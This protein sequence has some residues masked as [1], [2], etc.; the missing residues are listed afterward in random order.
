MPTVKGRA[1][2][3]GDGVPLVIGEGRPSSIS[4][5]PT[6]IT[7]GTVGYLRIIIGTKDVTFFRGMPVEITSIT[8][9]EPFGWQ[10]AHLNF[11]QI[12]PFDDLSQ[13]AFSWINTGHDVVIQ[14]VK[15]VNGTPVVQ[16][17]LFNGV[18]ASSTRVAGSG[19]NGR[20]GLKLDC[21]GIL[22]AN[23]DS[24]LAQPEIDYDSRDI[25]YV[26]AR[27]LNAV[28]QKRYKRVAEVVTGIKTRS[29]GAWEQN[30]T[31]RIGDL[32]AQATTENGTKQWTVYL[33]GGRKPVIR[34]KD[35][36]TV[37]HRTA[38]GTPG[39][40]I[41]IN[42][43]ASQAVTAIYGRGVDSNSRGWGNLKIPGYNAMENV[44]FFS[45]TASDTKEIG[46]TGYVV[47]QIQW[48]LKNIWNYP[49]AQDGIF[50]PTTYNFVKQLQR[51]TGCK[52]TGKVD[53]QTWLQLFQIGSRHVDFRRAY[54]AP[55]ATTEE[56]QPYTYDSSGKVTGH[57]P[58]YDGAT[59]PRERF[60][61]YPDGTSKSEAIG[62][63]NAELARDRD[64]GNTGT[65]T[66]TGVDPETTSKYTIR[67]G[68]NIA[69]KNI[70]GET[71][72]FHIIEV[73]H[74][75]SEHTTT[76]TVDTKCRDLLTLDVI[77]QRNRDAL[78]PGSSPYHRR[79]S[80]LT[81]GKPV[82][83]GELIGRIPRI[84]ASAKVWN[85]LAIPLGTEGNIVTVNLQTD[86]PHT[87]FSMAF[88]S[89]RVNGEQ[90]ESI[91][92]DPWKSSLV[93]DAEYFAFPGIPSV[94]KKLEDIAWID[95]LGGKGNRAGYFP[96]NE[97]RSGPITGRHYDQS[98]TLNF[99]SFQPPFVWLAFYPEYATF[100]EGQL[101]I[102]PQ[103]S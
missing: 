100:L 73:E 66:F 101:Y 59:I 27:Q 62:F 7:R 5:T 15:Y 47:E 1:T 24:V 43:D 36:E 53:A 23:A 44:G 48:G 20:V 70:G 21:Q 86:T 88:F 34:L 90:I 11:P 51:G 13:P 77:K 102:A 69:V 72:L 31:G 93:G 46:S 17:E 82:I 95:T 32:L 3:L 92:G 54:Y 38:F 18:I 76:L 52:V 12:T 71:L 26:I 9:G 63:A 98:I 33:M 55:L 60:H 6:A 57:N 16:A 94:Q 39:V 61:S 91:V 99:T 87:R 84:A 68:Q 14:L 79:R 97:E 85:V 67:A 29:T 22:Y 25:G 49:I 4:Y 28:K 56:S 64:P 30:L 89:A 74:S 58:L 8:D 2:L 19:A 96:G 35:Y 45:F 78:G 41:E 37:H 42:L 103:G 81:P 10:T 83:D 80:V 50:G 40:S 65:I 75:P